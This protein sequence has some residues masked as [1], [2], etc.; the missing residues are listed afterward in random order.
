[1]ISRTDQ[2]AVQHSGTYTDDSQM[3]FALAKS[4][5]GGEQHACVPHSEGQSA[6]NDFKRSYCVQSGVSEFSRLCWQCLWCVCTEARRL[7]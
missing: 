1:M 6:V 3:A 5:V 2:F 4:L 7:Q